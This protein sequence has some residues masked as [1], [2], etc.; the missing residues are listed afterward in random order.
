MPL[1]I[2]AV[3]GEGKAHAFQYGVPYIAQPE[4]SIPLHRR[5]PQTQGKVACEFLQSLQLGGGG[6]DSN[7][8]YGYP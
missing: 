3:G 7:L 4:P 8:R 1:R 2:K 6:K 5:Q